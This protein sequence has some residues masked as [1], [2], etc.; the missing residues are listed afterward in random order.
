[1][2]DARTGE[3][4]DP[5]EFP[6]DARLEAIRQEQVEIVHVPRLTESECERFVEEV[7][8][9][10]DRELAVSPAEIL[11][12]IHEAARQTIGDDE[13]AIA[14]EVFLLFHRLART[15]E[16]LEEDQSSTVLEAHVERIRS[17]LASRGETALAVG[18]LANVCNAAGLVLNPAYLHTPA[19]PEEGDHV[20]VRAALEVLE[21]ECLFDQPDS[22]AFRG[23][24]ESWSVTFL[25]QVLHE[26]PNA[27][28]LFGHTLTGL[29]S[30]ADEPD[31]RSALSETVGETP[32]LAEIALEPTAWSE[33]TVE[34]T[35]ELGRTH[36][37]LTP[38][39]EAGGSSTIGLPAAS[40]AEFDQDC[41]TWLGRMC[42][43]AGLYDCAESAFEQLPADCDAAEFEHRL[44][45]A[46]INKQY[47]EF[48][49]A[50][51]QATSGLELATKL[52]DPQAEARS[53]RLLGS[54]AESQGEYD[55]ARDHLDRSRELCEQ[56][57]RRSAG[58][59][60]RVPR[61]LTPGVKAV[62]STTLS[63]G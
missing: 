34:A 24:H 31:Q 42:K 54:I 9:L 22:S 36:P 15:F 19:L 17:E 14:G 37:K 44:G 10:T 5:E 61:S 2:L 7:E 6:I 47:G 12:D 29:L 50:K 43:N 25:Q 41:L 3:W 55:S 35:F 13:Q 58:G 62:R 28:E 8:T 33:E 51:T 4:T 32:V 1:L 45:L 52:E 57:E 40:P 11:A 60:G 38:L 48:D 49:T 30:L 59:T 39:F 26:T 16:P 63:T 21:D 23:I 18:V 53:E 20:D 56:I 46:R 27:A